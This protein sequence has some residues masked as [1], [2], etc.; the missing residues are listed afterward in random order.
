[1]DVECDR[2]TVAEHKRIAIDV[3]EAIFDNRCVICRARL[4]RFDRSPGNILQDETVELPLRIDI[5]LVE[6]TYIQYSLLPDLDDRRYEDQVRLLSRL[7]VL[8]PKRAASSV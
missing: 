5:K 6:D 2:L 1:M 8:A 4:V 7:V 3:V